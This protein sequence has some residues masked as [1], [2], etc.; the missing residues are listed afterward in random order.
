MEKL[1][2]YC[3]KEEK[4]HLRSNFSS[5]PQY[6]QYISNFRSRIT[7]SFEKCGCS[8]YFFLNSANVTCWGIDILKDYRES[9]GLQDNKSRLYQAMNNKSTDRMA[10]VYPK[11]LVILILSSLSWCNGLFHLWIWTHPLLQIW[12]SVKKSITKWQS[13]LIQM[14][15]KI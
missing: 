13:V 4:L 1:L 10:T 14:R 12:V 15:Y 3:G 5:F 11:Y 6:F 2:Q 7:Y 8:I 9:L